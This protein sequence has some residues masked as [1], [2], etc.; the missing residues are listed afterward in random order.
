[1]IR[2]AVRVAKADAEAVL[3]ELLELA[4]GGLEEREASDTEVEYVLYGAPGELPALPDVHAAAGGALV[5]VS[6]SEVPDDWAERWKSFHRPLD[7]SWRLRRLRVRPP[8]EERLTG[9]GIDL[10]IEPAQ[11][12]GRGASCGAR[13]CRRPGPAR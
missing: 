2:L 10:V 4:P 3:A 9:E 5:G 6:A 1:M 12:F 7:V 8:W 13:P 11:A